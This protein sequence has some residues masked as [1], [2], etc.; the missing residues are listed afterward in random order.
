M[1]ARY[2]PRGVSHPLIRLLVFP[3]AF[4]VAALVVIPLAMLGLDLG[5]FAGAAEGALL[6]AR[7]IVLMATLQSLIMLVVMWLFMF[8]W[9]RCPWGAIFNV[10]VGGQIKA[11]RPTIAWRHLGGGYVA[12]LILLGVVLGL[13]AVF[14]WLRLE[15]PGGLLA[16]GGGIAALWIL[17]Y[18][19]AFFIQG[20]TEEVIFRGYIFRNLGL[21]KGL[22][23]ALPGSSII[24]GVVHMFNPGG[25]VWMPVGNVVLV[26]LLLALIRVRYSLWVAVGFHA[27][28]NLLLALSGIPVSGLRAEGVA[29]FSLNG[30]VLW[31]GGQFGPEASVLTTI[32][33]VLGILWLL[34]DPRSRET[35]AAET[36][37]PREDSA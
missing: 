25:A 24:F 17:I 12:G 21:W 27:I 6:G 14:G 5:A 1:V 15:E 29:T 28:W 26:G 8:L 23:A 2:G 20:G 16:R 35:L 22:W 3:F 4:L 31:T 18:L 13:M 19:A 36:E 7:E 33:L 9:D 34:R 30:P 10:W 32:V 11:M 37:A